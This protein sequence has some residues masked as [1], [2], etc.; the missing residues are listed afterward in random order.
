MIVS[1]LWLSVPL[2]ISG[3]SGLLNFDRSIS[4][5]CLGRNMNMFMSIAK[6]L[7]KHNDIFFIV[8]IKPLFSSG[9]TYNPSPLLFLIKEGEV[10]LFLATAGPYSNLFPNPAGYP[11]WDSYP[12]GPYLNPFP[13]PAPA[14]QI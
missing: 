5:Y 4:L 13:N 12:S 2:R 7:K 6:A 14:G 3:F 11:A 1:E 9:S 8:G 10:F